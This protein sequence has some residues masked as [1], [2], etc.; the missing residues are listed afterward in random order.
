MNMA[1][2]RGSYWLGAAHNRMV[3]L[4]VAIIML[5]D[6]VNLVTGPP[7]NHLRVV[8][9]VR[10]NPSGEVHWPPQRDCKSAPSFADIFK[11]Q[12]GSPIAF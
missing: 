3:N 11:V 9:V 1:A 8:Q 5:G 6:D 12:R 7:V 2:D 4:R 10:A